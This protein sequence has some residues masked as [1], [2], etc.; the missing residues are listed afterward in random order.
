MSRSSPSHY[1]YPRLE[2]Q[3]CLAFVRQLEPV[4]VVVVVV[5]IV[6][7]AARASSTLSPRE[8]KLHTDA[9]AR[10]RTRE[11]TSI[12]REDMQSQSSR[13]ARFDVRSCTLHSPSLLGSFSHCFSCKLLV[14]RVGR[15]SRYSPVHVRVSIGETWTRISRCRSRVSVGLRSLS[16]RGMRAGFEPNG[17]NLTSDRNP[18]LETDCVRDFT[19]RSTYR[20]PRD[21]IRCEAPEKFRGSFSS[22]RVCR[23]PSLD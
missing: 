17:R 14:A 12:S 13:S 20:Y 19:T 1:F 15:S 18:I 6:A 5:D 23:L 11:R 7:L 9:R 22:F 10:V 8:F 16:F 3:S 21:M 4:V 2:V